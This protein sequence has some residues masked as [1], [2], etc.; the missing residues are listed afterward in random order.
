MKGSLKVDIS[1]QRMW[2]GL[3]CGP[4]LFYKHNIGTENKD[5][6]MYV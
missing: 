2:I 4:I 6:R 5:P 1:L 3:K